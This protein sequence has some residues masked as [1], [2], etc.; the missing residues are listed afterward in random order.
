MDN[1]THALAGMLVAEAACLARR[2]TRRE[3]RA[4]SYLVSALA[5]NLPDID[6]VYTWI[7]GPKP[8]GSLLHHRGH[9]HVLLVALALAWLLGY[10]AWRVLVR[11]HSDWGRGERRLLYGL[12][13]AG[14]L[15]HLTLDF[16]NNYGV[17]PFWPLSGRWFYGDTIF[18]VEPTWWALSIP[19]LATRVERRWLRALLWVLLAA[20]LVV[21]WFVP[22]VMTASRLA[23]L[24]LAALSW[25]L[26]W[27]AGPRVACAAV[28]GGCLLVPAA[29]AVS[30]ARAKSALREAAEAAFPAL[31]VHDIAATPL[32]A[33]PW[34]WEAFVAGE[35]GGIY[36]VLRASVALPP[37]GHDRCPAGL[38]V[39]PTAVVT[40]LTRARRGGVRWIHEY[41]LPVAALRRW[42][43]S[44]CFFRAGAQFFRLPY[45]SRVG[46]GRQQSPGTYAG[47]LRYDRS[48]DLDFSDMRLPDDGSVPCPRF[49]P[50]WTEPRA[51]LFRP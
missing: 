19:L 51:E 23:L 7:T 38:D 16:G 25:A 28:V 36:R 49:V 12:A 1:V 32:P 5:N 48:P 40:P 45:V 9:T 50:G 18:I 4:A 30:S 3:V 13:L 31:E 27:R 46:P 2:E 29:F 37:L 8:L 44:S 24:A 35:Q 33:N 34:C 11:R 17:H 22:F 41:T 10:V 43:Q 14:P 42:H 21:C 26:A 20:I 39:A 6:I 47:D 15:L